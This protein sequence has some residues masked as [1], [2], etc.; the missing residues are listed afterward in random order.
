MDDRVSTVPA[1]QAPTLRA[2]RFTL[3][4]TPAQFEVLARHAGAARWAFNHALGE[5]T[6]AHRQWRERVDALVAE[7]MPETWARKAVKVPM[8]RKE[9]IKKRLNAIKADTRFH[10]PLP[11]GAC[12]PPRPCPWWHEV[13]T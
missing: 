11:D 5:K 3:D 2:F 1:A 13:S 7:G 6:A 4:P 12:G 8:P 10:D 9:G